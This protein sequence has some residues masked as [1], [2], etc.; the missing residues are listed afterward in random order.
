MKNK[1]KKILYTAAKMIMNFIYFFIKLCRTK[2]KVTFISRQS[3]SNSLDFEL[4]QNKLKEVDPDTKIVVL[5]RR[6]RDIDPL[7]DKIKYCFHILVQ[8]YHIATSKVVVLET[9]ALPISMLKHKKSLKVIQMWH[10]LGSFKKFGFSVIDKKEGSDLSKLARMH[11]GYD[12]ILTS[13]EKARKNFSEAFGYE[14]KY[15]E[16]IPLPRVDYLMDKKIQKE[17]KIEI[18]KIYNLKKKKTIV[19]AP[20]FRK[21]GED[22]SKI[23]ELI[24]AVDYT[25]YNLVLKLHPLTKIDIEDERPISD[26][27]FSTIKWL[28]IADYVIT[29][30]SAIVYEAALLEKP[31]F[32]Y[33]YD[34]DEYE[35]GRDF[36]FNY[37]KDIPGSVKKKAK[38]II[39]DIENNNYNLEKV[40]KFTK[41][42]IDYD[43]KSNTLKIVELIEKFK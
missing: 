10:A 31:L 12:V 11:K 19:Y 18:N 4:V 3:N 20:T 43:G 15:F 2:N 5:N 35:V 14:E 13:S 7:K 27:K 37:K 33:A 6:F 9:Y 40:S 17:T 23:K 38:D 16:I 21:N 36:Y 24:D 34:Y 25:K 42:Y 1:I 41:D 32:F 22:I 39:K 8:M 30:Y 29:D 28:N 26:K